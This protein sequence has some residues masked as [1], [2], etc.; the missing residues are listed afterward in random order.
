MAATVAAD[1][2]HLC[3]H[4]EVAQNIRMFSH[5]VIARAVAMLGGRPVRHPSQQNCLAQDCDD[6]FLALLRKDGN[7][8]LAF[9][10]VEDRI[11]RAS[12]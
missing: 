11:R 12:L 8:H 5:S 9:L 10:D 3:S 1:E 7:L 4:R 2:R 6:G